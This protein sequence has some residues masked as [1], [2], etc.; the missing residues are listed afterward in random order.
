MLINLKEIG[1]PL[2]TFDATV[3]GLD[4][5]KKKPFPDI[6][7]EAAKKLKISGSECLVVEDAINGVEAAKASKAKCLALT[8]SFSAQELADAD[9]IAPTLTEV[10]DEALRW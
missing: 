9:W 5:E 6:F 2:E 3:N 7:L 8:T 1:I 10:P 4:V